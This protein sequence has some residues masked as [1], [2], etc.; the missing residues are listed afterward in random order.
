MKLVFSF[1]DGKAEGDPTRR[2]LLGGKGAGLAEMTSLGLPV[3]PG[4]TIST[5]ACRGF[6]TTGA[7]PAELGTRGRRR[8]RR[9]REAHRHALRR[10]EGPAARQRPLRRARVDAGHDGHDPEPRAQRRHRQGPRGAHRQPALRFDAYR[11]FVAM[12]ADVALG[13]SR[14]AL[15]A[16]PRRGP[17][18]ASRRTQ[19]IDATRLNAEELRRK[20]TDADIPAEELE[21]LVG[22]Q[23]DRQGQDE[24]GLPRRPEGAAL[25]GDPRGLQVVEQSARGRL[26]QD[27]RHPRELGDRLQ[28]AGDGL[29]QPRRHQRDRRRLHARPVD[30]RARPLRRVAPER[31]GRGRRRGHPHADA[32]PRAAGKNDDESLERRMP[33]AFRDARRRS[34]RRLEKHF[35]DMQDL[36]FTIQEGNL[37]MLQCRSAKRTARAAVRIAVEMAKEGLITSDEA[38]L[39]VDPG[40]LDQLLHPTLDPSAPKKLLARGLAGEPGRGAGQDRLQ[41]RRSGAPRRSGQ[42]RHPR[43]RRDVAGGHP[44]HEGRARHPHRARRD[45]EPRGSRG[46]R[47]GQAVRR[48]HAPRSP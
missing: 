31:A 26:P 43:A 16:R 20:V 25:V 4:F 5:E 11:R 14:R 34:A 13:V 6:T 15:R 36:E 22:V 40:A 8:A 42:G 29:R 39:R 21:A 33:D 47:D 18:R 38:V 24:E 46:A 44:R 17:R 23:G 35:R 37:Y 9:A 32:D 3:P 10:S 12:Y 1:G 2:D 30:R 27:A 45:D 19:G 41:R 48:R 28:R 7:M